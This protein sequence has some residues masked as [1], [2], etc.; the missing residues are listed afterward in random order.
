MLETLRKY[1]NT[2]NQIMCILFFTYIYDLVRNGFIESRRRQLEIIRSM[3]SR[4]DIGRLTGPTAAALRPSF[5]R[6]TYFASHPRVFGRGGEELAL[7]ELRY[8]PRAPVQ[9]RLKPHLDLL[10]DTFDEYDSWS[11]KLLHSN[12]RTLPQSSTTL[13]G[14]PISKQLGEPTIFESSTVSSSNEWLWTNQFD[15]IQLEDDCPLEEMPK[16]VRY[17]QYLS[18]FLVITSFIKY[19]CLVIFDNELFGSK[20]SFSCY[21][22]G[23]TAIL[24]TFSPGFSF[25]VLLYHVMYRFYLCIIRKSFQ[26]DSFIFLLYDRRTIESI[27]THQCKK[28]SRNSESLEAYMIYAM[29]RLFFVKVNLRNEPAK[30]IYRVKTNRNL[31]H[32]L[33]LKRFFNRFILI[34]LA[35]IAAWSIPLSVAIVMT[36][37]SEENFGIIYGACDAMVDAHRNNWSLW[38]LRQLIWFLCDMLDSGW[39]LFD[40]SNALVWPFASMVFCAQDLNYTIDELNETLAKV[41]SR[42]KHALEIIA[43]SYWSQQVEFSRSRQIAKLLRTIEIDIQILQCEITRML[44]QVNQVDEFVSKLSAFCIFIW[45]FTNLFVQIESLTQNKLV[46][47]DVVVQ[48]MQ[49][50]ALI[51]LT[52]SFAYIAQVNT[53]TRRL[54]TGICN[55]VALDPNHKTTKSSWLWVLEYFNKV[56]PSYSFRLGPFSE[57]T[58]L[59]YLKACSWLITG[60][61]VTI[62]L[63]KHKYNIQD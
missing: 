54:Y 35:N 20:Q 39:L 62:N 50:T 55:L 38:D 44:Q 23:R 52:L 22:P 31:E 9:Q 16:A 4:R 51:A 61:V 21:I 48:F 27:Q 8:R 41:T 5:L 10:I 56:K 45:I 1:L 30:V 37:L 2:K 26:L 25:V 6:N 15:E 7:G 42:L 29:N 11:P 33:K 17:Y 60:A 18:H 13:R 40:T 53:K 14:W 32:W 19:S 36:V 12:R 3:A 24:P 58:L 63:Y 34:C 46:V 57:L 28:L 43:A 59:N 49:I 47:L